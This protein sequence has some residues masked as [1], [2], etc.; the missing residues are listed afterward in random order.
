MIPPRRE[1][2]GLYPAILKF[3]RGRRGMSQLDLAIAAGISSRH[4][5]FLETRRA[6][7]SRDMVLRLGAVLG[8]SLRDQNAMLDAAGF[9]AE[10]DEPSFDAGLSPEVAQAITRMLAQ[11]EPFPL[12]IVD[13]CYDVVKMNRAAMRIANRF[14]AEP[15]AIVE[16]MNV[17]RMLFDPRLSRRFV[18]DWER[19]ARLMLSRVHREVLARPGDDLL[20]I[21]LR[22]LERYPEV[23]ASW[24]QPDFAIPC[25]PGLVVRSKRDDLEVG[26]LI[27]TTTFNAPQNVTLD[28]IRIDSY[29]PLDERTAET[30]VSLAAEDR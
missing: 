18:L 19:V 9:E 12:V 20:A 8:V 22:D 1:A 3:W 29:F 25:E 28:E 6:Q 16:P 11:Q 10:F 30:C 7:P 2:T 14:I 23:P 24:F 15:E 5:S 17:I 21:F 27:A 26:F 13:R 4:V